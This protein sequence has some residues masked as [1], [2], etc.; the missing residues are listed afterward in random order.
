[1]RNFTGNN[2]FAID[3]KIGLKLDYEFAVRL[4]NFILESK[5][6][7]KQIMAL[8]HNLCNLEEEDD[9]YILHYD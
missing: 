9:N 1:M 3:S 8:G 5:T 6:V 2:A 4:G 7:D